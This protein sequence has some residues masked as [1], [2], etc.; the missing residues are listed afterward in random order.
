MCEFL[1]SRLAASVAREIQYHL[2]YCQDCRLVLDAARKT[3]ETDF[4]TPTQPGRVR[5]KVA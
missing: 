2:E 5:S 4:A 3:L 1:D